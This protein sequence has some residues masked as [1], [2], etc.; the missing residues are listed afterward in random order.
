MVMKF[1]PYGASMIN[2]GNRILILFHLY[3]CS[4]HKLSTILIANVAN[5]FRFVT[6][7]DFDSKHKS[8]HL[9]Y[10]ISTYHFGYD[11]IIAF[12]KDSKHELSTI[13]MLYSLRKNCHIPPLPPHNGHLS[14]T[15]TFSCPQG[16]R[17]G[18]V[19]L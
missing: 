6:L 17:R 15:P 19:R 18:D 9:V 7:T 8:S 14:T 4:R 11:W 16:S 1:D 12:I 5:F 13:N 3:C 2:H 10:F